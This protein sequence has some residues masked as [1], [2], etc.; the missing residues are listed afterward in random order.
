M[1][2]YLVGFMASGKSTLGRYLSEYSGRSFRDLD[3]VVEKKAGM[4]IRE[5]FD[6]EGEPGFRIRENEALAQIAALDG[7]IVATGG[8]VVETSDNRR[9]LASGFTVF[10]D[11]NWETLAPWLKK[12][13]RYSR[14]LLERDEASIRDLFE[15]RLPLYRE[16]SDHV[17]SVMEVK[18]DSLAETLGAFCEEIHEAFLAAEGRRRR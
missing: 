1:N 6:R 13:S 12:V 16:V 7:F 18:H 17:A 14:P 4:P 15:R 5:I 3:R 9:L 10:L 11:W 2:L 8:G